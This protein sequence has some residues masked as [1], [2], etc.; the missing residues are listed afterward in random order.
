MP[1]SIKV[2][3]CSYYIIFTT[4]KGHNC[5]LKITRCPVGKTYKTRVYA[6]SRLPCFS[7]H[8]NIIATAS[9]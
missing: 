6:Y 3:L 7:L 9:A 1:W 5:I 4:T 2:F 8:H